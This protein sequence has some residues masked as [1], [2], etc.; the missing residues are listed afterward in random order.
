MDYYGQQLSEYMYF[1]L[2][3]FFGSVAWVV[4]W[5]YGDFQVTFYGWSVGLGLALI[6]CIPDWPMFNKKPVKWL[7]EVGSTETIEIPGEAEEKKILRKQQKKEAKA[8]ER[9]KR[10]EEIEGGSQSC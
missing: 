9:K 7:K 10:E 3:I 1:F 2:T 5:F 6:L 8:L 4:G